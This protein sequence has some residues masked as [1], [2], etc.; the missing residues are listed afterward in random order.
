MA[1]NGRFG[2]HMVSGHIDGIGYISSIKKDDNA[3]WYT[4]TPMKDSF[5][6]L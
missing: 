4:I 5:V 6:T 3:I 2:G 1:A